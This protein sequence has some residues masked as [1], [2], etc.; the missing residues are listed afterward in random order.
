VTAADFITDLRAFVI[1]ANATWYDDFYTRDWSKGVD[2]P[3]LQGVTKL[4]ADLSLEQREVLTMLL[5]KVAAEAS[6]NTLDF[7]ES[8]GRIW[9]GLWPMPRNL[10]RRFLRE[11]DRLAGLP[12]DPDDDL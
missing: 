3:F 2:T 1:D 6:G 4:Y 10:H 8:R 9:N 5:R 12:D 7:I 11:E